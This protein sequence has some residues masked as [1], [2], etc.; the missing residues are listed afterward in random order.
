MTVDPDR[1]V[2]TA[3]IND[4][5]GTLYG[6]GLGPG[7]PELVT[8]KAARLLGAVD[9]IA[10]HSARHGRS[11]ARARS[12]SLTCGP[13]QIEEALVYPVTTGSTDHPGGYEGAMSDFYAACRRPPV[14]P[15]ST[16]VVTSPCSPRVIRCSSAATCT[17]TSGSRPVRRTVIIPGITSI[18]AATAALQQPLVEGDDTLAD[19]ARHAAQ[20]T[21]R[22]GSSV[23][24]TPR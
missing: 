12:P 17:C 1:Q 22:R 9:V 19:A 16:P 3:P 7:D 2:I 8:V 21:A 24:P 23:R 4:R 11:I 20:R 13:G 6:V 14:R 18:S 15:I 5:Q 10:Y